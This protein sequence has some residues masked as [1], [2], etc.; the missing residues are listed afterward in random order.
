MSKRDKNPP[1]RYEVQELYGGGWDWYDDFRN[2]RLARKC[3]RDA[4]LPDHEIRILKV[5]REVVP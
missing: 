2:L 1:V 4:G 5:T 3:V